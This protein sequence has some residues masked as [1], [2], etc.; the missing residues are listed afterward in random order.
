MENNI[1][2]KNIKLNK[3]TTCRT[4]GVAKYFTQIDNVDDLVNVLNLTKKE[5][6]KV[7][8]LGGGS[9]ILI[10]DTGF[11]GLVIKVLNKRLKIQKLDNGY[12]EINAGAGWNLN[13]LITKLQDES[14]SCIEDLFGI[15]GTIGGSVRG[16][17][18]VGYF[19]IKDV[20]NNVYNID[21]LKFNEY[22]F[23][24]KKY[25]QNECGFGYRESIFKRKANVIWEVNL[26]GRQ[27]DSSIIKEKVK[28]TMDKRLK[29]QPYEFPNFGSTFKNVKLEE[30]DPKI[31]NEENLLVVNSQNVKQVPA[32]WLIDQCG[33]KGFSIN[34]AKISE[35]HANFIINFDKAKSLDIFNLISFIKEKV[36]EKFG[37]YLELEVQLIGF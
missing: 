25:N 4:G 7:F 36:L 6:L 10:N 20:V 13:N 12:F 11:D 31:W 34:G 26:I 32:G 8:V 2:L 1:I 37:V 19:E 22:N 9:N 28:N 17:C 24:I 5:G 3:F 23:E 27:M 29:S 33:L 21:W 15:P 30:F 16:N 35:K 14:I 18:G